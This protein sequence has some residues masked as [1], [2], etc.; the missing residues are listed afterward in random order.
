MKKKKFPLCLRYVP[1]SSCPY[2]ITLVRCPFLEI[3]FLDPKVEFVC[4]HKVVYFN[5]FENE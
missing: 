3:E 4:N 1:N 5:L 2:G